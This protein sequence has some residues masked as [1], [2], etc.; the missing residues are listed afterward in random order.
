MLAAK[1]AQSI[2]NTVGMKL[3]GFRTSADNLETKP[4]S[5]KSRGTE[6]GITQFSP[7]SA[8]SAE[9]E[10][11]GQIDGEKC[12][13]AKTSPKPEPRHDAPR[14]LYFLH[15]ASQRTTARPNHSTTKINKKKSTGGKQITPQTLS[16]CQAT[17]QG[18][19]DAQNSREASKLNSKIN[20]NGIIHLDSTTDTCNRSP[21]AKDGEQE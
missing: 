12:D 14:A 13:K 11:R 19:Y 2:S 3:L 7:K 18:F 10:R 15:H 20:T 1:N 5:H 16:S 17:S 6:L 9:R 21:T 4:K 8:A